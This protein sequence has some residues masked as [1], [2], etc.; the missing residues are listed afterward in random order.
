M[1]Q[2]I[3]N[4]AAVRAAWQ[5][6]GLIAA[7]KAAEFPDWARLPHY[8]LPGERWWRETID[9]GVVLAMALC[10]VSRD[11]LVLMALELARSVSEDL[12]P[13][14]QEIGEC[15]Y[16]QYATKER[17]SCSDCLIREVQGLGGKHEADLGMGVI[18]VTVPRTAQ[19]KLHALEALAAVGRAIA[20]ETEAEAL[21]SVAEAV[22]CTIFAKAKRSALESGATRVEREVLDKI[23]EEIAERMK[24]VLTFE[25]LGSMFAT[26]QA[27][28][29][30]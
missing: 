3:D 24:R 9:G 26:Q 30:A 2:Q 7:A 17:R 8:S 20:A 4:R 14:T 29:E 5:S 23:D 19:W 16:R 18:A 28:G 11:L 12:G 27:M 10:L 13:G 21:G 22:E 15:M 25:T 6:G 1:K